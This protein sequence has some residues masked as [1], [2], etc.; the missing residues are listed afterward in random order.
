MTKTS[1]FKLLNDFAALKNPCETGVKDT[2][3]Q[4]LSVSILKTPSCIYI[5]VL[6]QHS[7]LSDVQSIP[8]YSPEVLDTGLQPYTV[9]YFHGKPKHSI[10]L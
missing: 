6:D 5:L 3:I 1:S 9:L 2:Q 4:H 10:S 8:K 7:K